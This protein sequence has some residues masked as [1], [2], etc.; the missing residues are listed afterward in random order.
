MSDNPLSRLGDAIAAIVASNPYVLLIIAIVF[1]VVVVR[2]ILASRKAGNRTDSQ[3]PDFTN[4]A[5]APEVRDDQYI[6]T[7][8][9]YDD[10]IAR[11]FVAWRDGEIDRFSSDARAI[12]VDN[13]AMHRIFDR[14]LDAIAFAFK[15]MPPEDDEFLIAT[16]NGG[17]R[18]SYVLTNRCFVFFALDKGISAHDYEEAKIA[19]DDIARIEN[20]RKWGM[21]NLT[22]ELDTG[23][24]VTAKDL[25]DDHPANY[26]QH[27]LESQA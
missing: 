17:V 25:L 8:Q 11:T 2:P 3:V 1:W 27:R 21:N 20:S 23:R 12:A 26:L 15:D 5:Q 24:T 14:T 10:L 13:D 7:Q 9:D 6:F 19:L 16:R 4:D 22:I 18:T